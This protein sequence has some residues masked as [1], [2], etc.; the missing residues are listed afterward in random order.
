MKYFDTFGVMLDFSRNAVMNIPA[1]KKY[2]TLL[3]KFGYNQVQLY[4]EDT[5]EVD[6]EPFFGYFRG[7]YTQDELKDLDD[8][9]FGLGIEL[10]PCIQTLAHMN[11][12]VRWPEYTA[13]TDTGDILMVGE[14]RTYQLIENMFSSLRKCFRTKHIHIGM[15]EAHMLGRGKYYDKHGDCDHTELLLGHLIK[16]CDLADKYGFEPMMWSDMFY[17]IATGGDYYSTKINFDPEIRKRMPEKLS[18]VYWDYY[19]SQKS[20]YTK[21]IRGHKQITD[22]VVFGGGAWK[23]IGFAPNN[24]WSFRATKAAL[25]A[26]IEGGIRNAFLTMWGDDGSECPFNA[27]LPSLCYAACYADGITDPTTIR[28][29]FREVVGGDFDAFCALDL[30]NK[31]ETT[32]DIVNPCRYLL[33]NDC[34]MGIFDSA[35]GENYSKKY[36]TFARRLANYGKKAGEYAY[37]FDNL[38]KL[39]KALSLKVD[40]G[41]QTRIAYASGEK[42]MLDDLIKRYAKTIRAVDDFYHAFRTQWYT[43][44]KPHGFDVQDIRLGGLMNRLKS[45]RDRLVDL[46]DGKIDCIPELE[47]QP[48]EFFKGPSYFQNWKQNVSANNI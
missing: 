42:D 37:L 36:A 2:L 9:A 5:Y 21:M 6:G 46:R 7:R 4:T 47:E 34:F 15:D 33:Y 13:I 3:S 23:W 40:L 10:V 44:N 11:A 28:A 27:V 16:V 30:P 19:H 32:P 8:F 14:D 31:V 26:C 24:A 17:R 39:C 41:Q 38:S 35:V 45:C 12:A 43:E 22:R 18:L 48:L 29:K 20:V 1:L 25:S